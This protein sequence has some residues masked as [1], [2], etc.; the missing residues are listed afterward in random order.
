M[1]IYAAELN[2]SNTTYANP[3][4]LINKNNKSTAHNIRLLA[5]EA[6]KDPFFRNIVST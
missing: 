5:Y 4:G 3:H 2:M 6:I 1:N